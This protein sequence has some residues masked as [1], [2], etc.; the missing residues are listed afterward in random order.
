ML[1]TS[2]CVTVCGV[3]ASPTCLGCGNRLSPAQRVS[4]DEV[5]DAPRGP[6]VSTIPCLQPPRLPAV[7]VHTPWLGPGGSS[8]SENNG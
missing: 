4:H 5:S 3:S 8:V 6:G 2:R 7:P 1:P